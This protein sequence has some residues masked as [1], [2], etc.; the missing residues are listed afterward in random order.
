[1]ADL[2]VSGDWSG[3][4]PARGVISICGW[5]VS[6]VSVSLKKGLSVAVLGGLSVD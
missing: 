4:D 6:S 1:M 2:V 5:I 3:F